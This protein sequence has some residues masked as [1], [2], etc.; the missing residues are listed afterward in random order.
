MKTTFLND[1]L[2]EKIYME[3]LEGC[4]VPSQKK[5][6]RSWLSHYMI[7]NKRLNNDTK[8]LTM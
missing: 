5:K 2:Y 1:K 6:V 8:S 4:V 3:Q 7:W